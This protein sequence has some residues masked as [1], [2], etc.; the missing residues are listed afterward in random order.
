MQFSRGH[1]RQL[2][3]LSSV[4]NHIPETDFTGVIKKLSVSRT[5]IMPG[6]LPSIVKRGRCSSK[7]QSGRDPGFILDI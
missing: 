6:L 4:G 2:S 3:K 7:G 1:K 5:P